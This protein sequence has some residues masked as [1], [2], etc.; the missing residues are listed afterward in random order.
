MRL[1]PNKLKYDFDRKKIS[2]EMERNERQKMKNLKFLPDGKEREEIETEIR[3]RERGRAPL[4]PSSVEEAYVTQ[5][6]ND[7][8]D[9]SDDI[10]NMNIYDNENNIY[11]DYNDNYGE[12]NNQNNQRKSE[13]KKF[14]EYFEPK[15]TSEESIKSQKIFSLLSL[16]S[17]AIEGEIL[18][19][20]KKELKWALLIAEETLDLEI[21]ELG[22][23]NSK[24]KS[25]SV[26][27]EKQFFF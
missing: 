3:G 5:Y 4:L 10:E 21:L 26:E 1:L 23:G 6:G 17:Q 19:K 11:N 20:L 15:L 24:M 22:L 8:N 16:L 27:G 7:D 14:Q 25:K 2:Q 12:E 9:Y 13:N 18:L